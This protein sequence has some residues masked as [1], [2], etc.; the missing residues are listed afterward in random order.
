[1]GN[2]FS[3]NQNFTGSSSIITLDNKVDIYAKNTSGVVEGLLTGRWSD[4]ATYL[5]YGSG[6]LFIRNNVSIPTIYMNTNGNVGIGNL[7]PNN[8]LVVGTGGAY[9][10]GTTWVSGS[11]RNA[12]EDFTQISPLDVLDKVSAMPISEWRYKVDG[13]GIK[14]LG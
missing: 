10:N 2:T 8:L 12:K 4:N 3:G 11:D 14:H 9:C 13:K 7:F 5:T 1:G 6:G